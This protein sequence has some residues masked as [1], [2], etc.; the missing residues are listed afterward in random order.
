M[1]RLKRIKGYTQYAK[2]LAGLTTFG[3]GTIPRQPITSPYAYSPDHIVH[4]WLHN[5][6]F[7]V[8]TAHKQYDVFSVPA[9]APFTPR[10]E[11]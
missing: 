4:D 5:Q 10:E 2:F 3:I 6:V 1:E 11:E 8:E 7:I 9:D